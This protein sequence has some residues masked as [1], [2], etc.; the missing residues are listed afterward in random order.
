MLIIITKVSFSNFI[1]PSLL[2]NWPDL[3]WR[4]TK[5]SNCN[6]IVGYING[7][8]KCHACVYTLLFSLV[9]VCKFA[10]PVKSNTKLF[11]CV[12]VSIFVLVFNN[13]ALMPMDR[14]PELG[15]TDIWCNPNPP[16]SIQIW[17]RCMNTCN[18]HLPHK[19]KIGI[20]IL[21]EWF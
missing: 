11:V 16:V 5:A 18:N 15:V 10:V 8:N 13:V 21:L 19:H 20:A 1:V 9:I 7:M 2:L 3:N 4:V 14:E 6:Y 17:S 12:L